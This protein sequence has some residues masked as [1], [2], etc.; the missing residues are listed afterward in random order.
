VI[1]GRKVEMIMCRPWC[2]WRH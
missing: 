1:D 2:I